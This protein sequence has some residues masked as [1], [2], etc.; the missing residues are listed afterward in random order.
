[1]CEASDLV[2]IVEDCLV[3]GGRAAGTAWIAL[4]LEAQS[5]TGMLILIEAPLF[6]FPVRRVFNC[7][8]RKL[9]GV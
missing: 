6:V 3:V 2:L 4:E 9:R 7:R 1:M 5:L 8:F